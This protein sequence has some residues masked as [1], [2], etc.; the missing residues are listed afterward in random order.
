MDIFSGYGR[1]MVRIFSGKGDS[2]ELNNNGFSISNVK[3]MGVTIM[4]PILING[5]MANFLRT[6]YSKTY[7]KNDYTRWPI[8]KA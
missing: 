4:K 7:I 3:S 8:R 2:I 1:N 6:G 5:V